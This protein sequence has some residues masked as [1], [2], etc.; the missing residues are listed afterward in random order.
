MKYC[1]IKVI[2]IVFLVKVAIRQCYTRCMFSLLKTILAFCS[3]Y[4]HP[5]EK[6][7]ERFFNGLAEGANS[8]RV[9]KRLLQ[10]MQSNMAVLQLWCERRYKGYRDLGKKRRKE[11][12]QRSLSLSTE[13]EH[14]VEKQKL[15][16]EPLTILRGINHFL[17]HEKKFIYKEGAYFASLLEDPNLK[18][19]KGDCNQMVTLYVFLYSRFFEVNTLSIKL[20]PG[21]IC[22]HFQGIDIETTNGKIL[23][24]KKIEQQIKPIEELVVVNLIDVKDKELKTHSVFHETSQKAHQLHFLLNTFSKTAQHNLKVIQ[25]KEWIKLYKSLG[26]IKSIR[27]LRGK[28][29]TLLKMKKIAQELDKKEWIDWCD[30]MMP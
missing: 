2:S 29:M 20:F 11:L 8:R 7:V 16:H 19:L 26:T 18:T 4:V 12:I 21:H 5:N 15:K 10:F 13:F 3:I 17:H 9:R 6:K 27:L 28:R 1:C 22:L 30:K 23:H 24:Y 25:Q 14:Y